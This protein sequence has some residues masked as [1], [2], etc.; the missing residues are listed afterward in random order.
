MD[1]GLLDVML[2]K[3][4]S[5]LRIAKV[6]PVYQKGLHMKNGA[7]TTELADVVEFRRCRSA[8]IC[9]ADSGSKPI[10]ANVDGECHPASG[11]SV[12]ILPL[13]GRAILPAKI[14]ARNKVHLTK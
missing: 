10:I 7:I 12:R 11:L 13:A 14:Y 5:L 9:L 4:M 8:Q 3:K 1:D 2:V 6:L